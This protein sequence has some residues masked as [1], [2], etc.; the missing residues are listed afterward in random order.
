MQESIAETWATLT[1]RLKNL[2]LGA[3]LAGLGAALL[4]FAAL[5]WRSGWL[6][7][8]VPALVALAYGF[9]RRDAAL[10][11]RWEDGLY[12][13]WG[14]SDFCMG[15]FL[16]TFEK[17][18]GPLKATLRSMIADLPPNPDYLT[19][20]PEEIRRHRALYW[21][22]FAVEQLRLRRGF[23]LSLAASC[24]PGC[25]WT[26]SR[27][28]IRLIAF[29]LLPLVLIPPLRKLAGYRVR[30]N[31]G[32]RLTAHFATLPSP[33][34]DRPVGRDP[35]FLRRLREAPRTGLPGKEVERLERVFTDFQ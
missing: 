14:V 31:L 13:R 9:F 11:F 35:E 17:N 22:R 34:A 20:P 12:A 30:R 6:W 15:I 25:A 19:P 2:R 3:A 32:Q 23:A 24:V 1:A 27:Q 16:E 33:A 28:D 8:G 5:W 4:L 21:H 26:L 7:W 29:G 10:L 18:P